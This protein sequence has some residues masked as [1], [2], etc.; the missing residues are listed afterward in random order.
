MYICVHKWWCYLTRFLDNG[1]Y[2]PDWRCSDLWKIDCMEAV[3]WIMKLWLEF[4]YKWIYV[5]IFQLCFGLD[6]FVIYNII[7][8]NFIV[9]FLFYFWIF[10]FCS[11]F[12]VYYIDLLN[13]L[14]CF[15]SWNEDMF[16]KWA[17]IITVFIVITRIFFHYL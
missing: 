14:H 8:S 4:H 11:G 15:F 17:L 12:W 10:L 16:Y 1:R 2:W 5:F 7:S 3:H 9:L 13:V 6:H